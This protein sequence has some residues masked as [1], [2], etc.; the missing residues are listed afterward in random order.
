M[1][2]LAHSRVQ[3]PADSSV[4]HVLGDPRAPISLIEYG[5]YDCLNCQAAH[6]RVLQL[7]AE[8]GDR[9]AYTF[10]HR[11]IPGNRTA[12]RAAVLVE[13]AETPA[14]F[15]KAHVALMK[16]PLGVDD[17]DLDAL[18]EELGLA[19]SRV[20][21]A[22]AET[23][24]KRHLRSAEAS[25]VAATPTFYINGRRYNGPWDDASLTDALLGTLGHRVQVA[26]LDF[27]NWAPSTGV[28]LLL[29]TVFA[30]VISNT[31]IGSE[32]AAFWQTQVGIKWGGS[33][34]A[35]SL[36]QWINDGLLTI[37]FLVV[38][39]EI[40]REFTVGH[41]ASRRRAALPVAGALGGMIV[42]ALIY[43]VV[44]PEGPWKM[45]WGVPIATDTAF[46][47]AI[48]ATI[49]ARAPVE[50]RIFLTAA[51]IVDD[52]AAIAVVAVFYSDQIT[53]GFLLGSALVVGSLY[54]V[55]RAKIHRVTIYVMLGLLLWVLV[56]ASGVHATLAGVIMALFIPTRPAPDYNTLQAQAQTIFNL[57]A[58]NIG[59]QMRPVL[60]AD[61]LRALDAI[62]DRLESPAQRMLRHI[63]IRS[64]YIVLPIFALA[65]AGVVLSIS[66]IAGRSA[67]MLGILLGLVVGK[68]IG[69]LLAA[70]IAVK[71]RIAEKPRNYSWVQLAGA[72]C[73]AGIG[74]T[75]SLFIASQ[76]F[77]DIADFQAA[78]LAVFGASA[79]AATAGIA[80]LWRA[81]R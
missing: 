46:A 14:Q 72:S 54:A 61:S 2:D 9:L 47:V 45:G 18:G 52:I 69:L 60:S 21:P 67:L 19:T 22:E 32:Y 30:V 36:L 57:E 8:F 41:L 55:N 48:M 73:L 24:L 26:A 38:G 71:L 77:P 40:K 76:A 81:G 17:D 78:K 75:M 68:P 23:H 6:E 59:A 50:L 56:H 74:F 53:P 79:V 10:R 39:L 12:H 20:S 70:W 29:A 64:T 33:D 62:H 49:G 5:S 42:P 44:V 34:F 51:A 4:D 11:P 63:E 13:R 43:L 80:V 16:L 25:G 58:A 3:P 27:V 37:F 31:P 28:L 7:R 15:W 66:G 1:S 65:N 35:L